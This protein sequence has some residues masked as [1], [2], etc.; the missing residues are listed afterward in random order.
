[1]KKI[2][3]YSG[4]LGRRTLFTI[5]TVLILA[6]AILLN[7][8]IS[9]LGQENIWQMDLTV[10]GHTNK[11]QK[12]LKLYTPSD[13]FMNLI[14][15]STLPMVDKVNAE[16]AAKGEEP[17]AINIIFCSDRDVVWS[18]DMMR[19][20]L[21]TALALEKEFGEYFNVDF[22][23]IEKNPSAVQKYKITSSSHIYNSNVIF[24]FGSEFRV[25]SMNTFFVTN[26]S[27]KKWAYNGEK[28][29]TNA[30]L[31]VTRAEAPIACFLNNHGEQLDNIQA[32]WNLVEKSGYEVR[33][34]DM[35][36]EDIPENCRLLICY[37]PQTDFYAF[38]NTGDGE[39]SEI[40]K[41]DKFLD[42]CFSFLLFVDNETPKLKNL[43]EY[44]E[45]WGVTIARATVNQ[46][47]GNYTIRD[48]VEKLDKDGYTPIATYATTGLGSSL[49]ADMRE[50][51]YPAKVIFPNATA[52]SM[53]KGYRYT[54]VPADSANNVEAYRYGFYYRNGVSRY[55][56]DVFTAGKNA[57][58]EVNGV[59]YEITTEN[60]S[61]SLMTISNEER[62]RQETNYFSQRDRSFVAVIGS[63]EFAS[64][65]ILTSDAYG[66]ADVL[67]STL[68]ALG[69][70][71]APAE[72]PFTIFKN[73]EMNLES[74]VKG[75]AN[76]SSGA[77]IATAVCLAAI[78]ALIFFGLGIYVNVRRKYK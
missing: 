18:S 50:L 20:I 71:V 61:F 73:Y 56:N 52:I 59:Q 60:K 29:F 12:D 62:I 26:D 13:V 66:N 33:S 54:Y 51:A 47:E 22:I 9:V 28:N 43:E 39:V 17:I 4:R 36:K 72:F 34:L 3:N 2:E 68:R 5:I 64:D 67:S 69:R 8:L 74:A 70:E 37:D 14:S 23:N 10:S 32:L 49:T 21:Y 63:T 27:G 7:L 19:C 76:V 35:T 25:Y 16:R 11:E 55:F 44:L 57:V 46:E 75:G 24:E 1:M 31:A 15:D 58:A 45:E 38:G 30:I 78:P 65:T 41:L 53:A 40:D 77:M 48:T 42:N 6:V